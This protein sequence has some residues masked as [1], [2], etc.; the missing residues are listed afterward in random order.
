MTTLSPAMERAKARLEEC[1]DRRLVEH[2]F[3]RGVALAE[4]SE[5]EGEGPPLAE[6]IS[7]IEVGFEKNFDE[8]AGNVEPP[9]AVS[10][11]EE[12]VSVGDHEV[13]LY[14]T[15]PAGRE[16]RVP[17]VVHLHG[18]GMAVCDAKTAAYVNWRALLAAK[19]LVVVGVDFRNSGGRRG[20][21]PYPAGLEDCAAA[22]EW[23]VE[24]RDALNVSSIVLQGESGGGNL[25]L[26]TA[27]KT[28]DT[29]H[30]PDGVYAMCPFIRGAYDAD[31]IARFP[32]LTENNGIL[33]ALP[34]TKPFVAAYQGP[35]DDPCAWPLAADTEALR[36]FPPCVISVNELDIYRDEGLA[37][38][39]KL[40]QAG[41]QAQARVVAGTVHAADCYLRLLPDLADASLSAIAAFAR[42]LPSPP[43][44]E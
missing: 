7:A 21:H 43:G 22:L 9:V 8:V 37:M 29:P 11:T 26:A 23:T 19:G 25:V 12:S 15:R 4:V 32:S 3:A 1:G 31:A 44:D 42:S 14:I 17:C 39:R 6:L 28:K 20:P 34:G 36:G 13:A 18:G 40:M 27:I 30:R 24:H 38:Y 16:D 5:P 35:F 33:L 2:L 10:T 41:C